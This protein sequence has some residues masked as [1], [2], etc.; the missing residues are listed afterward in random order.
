VLAYWLV[1]FPPCPKKLH[2]NMACG[3]V[4]MKFFGA[5]GENDEPIGKH[6]LKPFLSEKGFRV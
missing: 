6:P 1:I 4:F 2:E 5:G 3:H